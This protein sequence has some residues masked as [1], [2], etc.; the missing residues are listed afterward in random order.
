MK[1]HRQMKYKR[2]L[3]GFIV[4]LMIIGSLV[5]NIT[6]VS[7]AGLDQIKNGEMTDTSNGALTAWMPR[8]ISS[9]GCDSN[10]LARSTA[11]ISIGGTSFTTTSSAFA[12]LR[13]LSGGAVPF[14]AAME[15]T[16]LLP[17]GTYT[18]TA[19]TRNNIATADSA[20]AYARINV[21][22]VGGDKTL[23]LP[24]NEGWTQHTI[25]GIV[26]TDGKCTVSF[27]IN[28]T[29]TGTN[30]AAGRALAIDRV[31]LTDSSAAQ[32]SGTI[33]DSA[34]AVIPYAFI[35]YLDG[36][37]NTAALGG[38]DANGAY[39]LSA[40]QGTYTVLVSKAGFEDYTTPITISSSANQTGVNYTLPT[41]A[42]D[43]YSQIQKFG[44]YPAPTGSGRTYYISNSKGNDSNDGLSMATPW[45]TL[46]KV[47]AT[48]GYAAGSVILLKAGDVWTGVTM[49]SGIAGTATAPITVGMYVDPDDPSDNL[50]RID[51][52]YPPLTPDSQMTTTNP[53]SNNYA[54]VIN[55]S[56][57]HVYDLEITNWILNNATRTN[58]NS[59]GK[60]GVSVVNQSSTV[61]SEGVIL[62]NLY[63]H[64]VNGSNPKSGG[65]YNQAQG[66]GINVSTTGTN[67][68]VNNLTIENCLLKHISRNGIVTSGY[69]AGRIWSLQNSDPTGVGCARGIDNVIRGN[70]LEDIWGDGI[71]IGGTYKCLVESNLVIN[72]VSHPYKY[73]SLTGNA[74]S[75]LSAGVWP[76]DSDATIFQYNEVCYT[77]VPRDN[78]VADGEAFDSDYY[79]TNNLYQYNYTH[80]NEG[81]FFMVCGPESS[82]TEGSV[83]RYNISVN[84]GS[85]YGK[86]S[87][88]E[89][90]GGGGVD[91]T[92]IY[93]NTI[94]TS[95]DHAVFQVTRGEPWEGKSRGTHFVNNIFS[96]N[97]QTAQF[98]W[99]GDPSDRNQA[100][101]CVLDN[102]LYHGSLFGPGLSDM[103]PDAHPIFG[104]P[105]FV[106]PGKAAASFGGY[107]RA[108]A[109]NYKIQSGSAAIGAGVIMDKT[110]FGQ[111]MDQRRFQY[112]NGNQS[113]Q[114]KAQIWHK[115]TPLIDYNWMTVFSDQEDHDFF[116]N[117]IPIDSPP[118]I[119]AHQLGQSYI[120]P[121]DETDF[122]IATRNIDFNDDWKFYLATRT[123]S[124]AG[125][126]AGAGFRDYGLADAGGVTTAQVI[127][128]TFNDGA[129][130]TVNLPHD[131]AIEGQKTTTSSSNAQ[132]YMQAGL[133]WYR[134]TF[135]LPE[136][137][138]DTKRITIDFDGVYQNP[139]V[140]V[141]GEFVGNYPSGYSGFAFDITD[142]LKYGNEGPNVIVVK[143]QNISSSGRWYTGS[144]IIR[145]VTLVVTNNTRIARNGLVLSTPG[146]ETTYGANGS[147]A[148]NVSA[149]VYSYDEAPVGDVA[150]R[151]TIMD[152]DIVVASQTSLAVACA[153]GAFTTLT[154]T[155]TVPNVK[156]WTMEDPFRYNIVTELLK[157]GNGGSVVP[158]AQGEE[159]DVVLDGAVTKFG[160]R[161]FK[162]TPSDG[163]Y[164][165]GVYTKIQG[166]DLHHDQGSLGAA[167]NYDALK[168]ELSI[169]KS[170]GV[171][172]YRTSHCP[173]SKTVID[174]CSELGIVV[175]EEAFDS[176]GSAKQT[177]DFGIFFLQPVPA[178][179]PGQLNVPLPANATWSDW[180]IKEMVMR[181]INEPS[182]VM[183]SIGNEI[184]NAGTRPSWYN[185]NDYY[186]ED[187][188][189]YTKPSSY[190]NTTFNL[191][192]ETMRLRNAILDIDGTRPIVCGTNQEKSSP[193]STSTWGYINHSLDG[194]GLN[195]NT[196]GSVDNLMRDYPNIFF[197]ESESS[198]QTGSRGVYFSPTLANTPPNQTPGNRGVS[199]YD[200]QFASWTVPNEY[201]LKKDRDR[202]GFVGQYIWSGF[203]YIG[204]PTPFSI[205]PV[206][207]S[208]FGTIDTAGFPK[209]SYYLFRSQW[210]K[211]PMAHLVPMNWND[212]YPG[213]NVEVWVNTNGYKAELFL[214]GKSLGV[215][216]FDKKTTSYGLEYYE[217]T[218]ATQDNRQNST[219]TNRGGYVSPNNSY[220]KLHLTW[221]VPFEP[222]ELKVIVYDEDGVE[223]ATD[224]M[225]TAGS[226]YTISMK[227]DK[228]YLQPDGRSL[229]YVECD[230]V[231]EN[232]VM[233]PSANNLVKF[234]IT[235]AAKIFGVDN[236][237]SESTELYK[238]DS[239][240]KNTHSE[241][242]AYN[243]KVLV[244]VQ[245]EKG[246][247]GFTLTASSDNFV[248]TVLNMA[249]VPGIPKTITHPTLGTVVSTEKKAVVATFGNPT[250]LPRDVKVTY[251]S[252]VSLLKK[253]IW[254]VDPEIFDQ[255]G[256]F[257]VTGAFEDTSI[258]R[259]AELEL[260]VTLPRPRVN[261]GL[262]TAAGAQDY[263]LT[264][265]SG[266][267][268]T[269]SFTSA[270][271]YPNYMLNGNTTNSWYNYA[272]A[273]QT[274]EVASNTASRV[275]E[276][277]QT[278]WPGL[279]T[280]DQ[281]S[282][283]FTTNAN[284]SLPKTL[285][286][287]YWDGFA[288]VDAPNQVVTFATASNEETKITFD[289][290]T[291]TRV[292]VGMENATPL[293]STT[294][295]MRIVK[296][297]TWGASFNV[298][299]LSGNSI[300]SFALG[301]YEGVV[302]DNDSTI[303]VVVPTELDITNIAPEITTSVDA[304]YTPEGPQDFTN[305][306][307]YTVL[308]VNGVP[309]TYTVTVSRSHIVSFNLYGGDIGGDT[310]SITVMIANGGFAS[311][312][313]VSPA[314][315]GY[316][317]VGWNT[318]RL[319]TTAQTV[320]TVAITQNTTF[321]AIWSKISGSITLDT[322]ADAGLKTWQS[323]KGSNYGSDSNMLMRAPT[324]TG[325]N[326]LF[327]QNF[328]NTSTSDG[329]DIKT[330]YIKFDVSSLKGLDVSSATLNLRYTGN[331]NSGGAGGNTN[332]LVARVVDSSWTESG[333]TWNNRPR[334]LYG[335]V[336]SAT[337]ADVAR[338][339][340]FSAAQST[341]VATTTDVLKLYNTLPTTD[342]AITF[343]VT[344]PLSNRDYQIM[345]KEGAG[346][347]A[348]NRPRLVLQVASAPDYAVTYDLNGGTGAEPIQPTVEGGKTFAAAGWT[349][350]TGPDGKL[351]EQ[352][353]TKS[354]G[355]G[356][357]YPAGAAVTMPAEN[358]TL[359]AIW[360]SEKGKIDG[361]SI[362]DNKVTSVSIRIVDP[363]DATVLLAA[364]DA[365]GRMIAISEYKPSLDGGIA[366]VVSI[367]F[368]IGAAA[369]VKAFLW[370]NNYIPYTE[371]K[372]LF[373][374]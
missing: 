184:S 201:G 64:H 112:S 90:G 28:S 354:D 269:A 310:S 197:F 351:F 177:Y 200:N 347:T 98:G 340:T 3:S 369:L 25:T 262:N 343:A 193:G 183:W 170:M 58:A 319:A 225:K 273:T 202:K 54:V 6:L 314:R 148:L 16:M 117:P 192:T 329:T 18:L 276:Y 19:Y 74:V 220:G 24:R 324:N 293:N 8:L 66:V 271:N 231:D 323:E 332:L 156:L 104:D 129:W 46:S 339:A 133:G 30:A 256:V 330:I 288:W 9:T 1:K 349:G 278:Y 164:L 287:Q 57:W 182:V 218:E 357:G 50:P 140:Y 221:I 35:K 249:S 286:A 159:D 315:T 322:I 151:T 78:E 96:I 82:Y 95:P 15:Q 111:I 7:A 373:S 214:N 87:I 279:V 211:E 283:F 81:G 295:R 233:L 76:F 327:G 41:T 358:L 235:G 318:N 23:D 352:W 136:E 42:S 215:K 335:D 345:S 72:S 228:E 92:W 291:T 124:V 123:P 300:L 21:I 187:K 207:T 229:V 366:Q 168:R 363:A 83:V 217:T 125:G 313:D 304:T 103:P 43:L 237:K 176:W 253:V 263:K 53:N 33:R 160:F 272:N 167:A 102:N 361:F 307:I 67:R 11:S 212:Y 260:T 331:T 94:Y 84:D 63:I 374:K 241:R 372:V 336:S 109:D 236:G 277:V 158:S 316:T 34:G 275:Y 115:S 224:T 178:N 134:K 119:G 248:P 203:D 128:P 194:I 281:I 355:T 44:D 280:V 216:S 49:T 189:L 337:A 252:G 305:P 360:S 120:F 110:K 299:D 5:T 206:S 17:N 303:A 232:G 38:A 267:L 12:L 149:K 239:L 198:S 108:W 341:A 162:F 75:N 77:G 69:T 222:G 180:V 179:Y 132:G 243:G 22:T 68:R 247:G 60:G 356:T 121:P 195:Y 190:T 100:Y 302:N 80:D 155:V 320:G 88:F 238:W 240:D 107:G 142:Y 157:I 118:D 131:Y 362:A 39:S 147:A 370:D 268:A 145:P 59:A 122:D 367:D 353:N 56:Y 146:L 359:Y 143:C 52:N 226:A 175:M 344:I 210:T 254:D 105:K 309:R 333:I 86:R 91:N 139:N 62:G 10:T 199:A 342:N 13:S 348:A 292:R 97:G 191:H 165:N 312:L 264:D 250:I 284:D 297:E 185:W 71:L 290:V 328:T 4:L 266:P 308:S 364:Y 371:Q 242:E 244:I 188:D 45:K 245:S 14:N 246:A 150:L 101:S 321:Y 29:T 26:V 205:F 255:F 173:P 37:G 47:S 223:F 61:D 196:A 114:T 296:F 282:L 137:I 338:S 270:T 93:N 301:G 113:S 326:G 219:S 251:S 32:I 172:S 171:N 265:G 213:E 294:G 234:D 70:V 89:I 306:V 65:G 166:V 325:T 127:S 73:S 31:T 169:L 317:F 106:N 79:T 2:F 48:T 227:P 285:N 36:S 99:P 368:D 204:E 298:D 154:D 27:E 181:D 163:F 289:T 51:A 20:A 55:R 116:D 258:S 334:A 274:D 350:L 130:R 208:F 346:N 85:M 257:T 152:G 261:Y 161:W 144:G 141:N 174:L 186:R 230:I 126:S 209:D 259:E 153:A 365:S 138:R 40:A 135:T 311:A